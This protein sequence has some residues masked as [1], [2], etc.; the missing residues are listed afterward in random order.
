MEKTELNGTS[1]LRIHTELL[2]SKPFGQFIRTKEAAIWFNLCGWII[3]GPL[4]DCGLGKKLYE[5]FYIGQK[6]LV[7]RWDQDILAE[8]VGLSRKSKGYI[9][10]L[11][12][13]LEGYWTVIK[14]IKIPSYQLQKI[15]VY[16]LGYINESGDENLYL[17]TELRRRQ[18]EI[19]YHTR[20]L[21]R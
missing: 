15:N 12:K 2:K 8:H 17:L 10:R 20:F 14:I 18:I 16:E 11:L 1:H 5:E 9:S 6:K 3:R 19:D 4:S 13:R 7:A 21:K